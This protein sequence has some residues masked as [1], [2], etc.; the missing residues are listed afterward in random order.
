MKHFCV[1]GDPVEHSLSPR[2]HR[3]MIELT[4]LDATYDLCPVRAQE[5]ERFVEQARGGAWDGFNVTMP[6]K[7]AVVPYLDGLSGTA[8]RCRA[9]NTVCMEDGR[10]IGHNTDGLGFIESLRAHG[11]D[12]ADKTALIIGTGGAGE[13][14]TDALVQAGAR[15]VYICN[16]SVYRAQ[17]LAARYPEHT[18]WVYF[19]TYPVRRG[20]AQADLV[21]NATSL[22]MAGCKEFSD[23][24]FLGGVNPEAIVYD[25]VY[26]PRRTLFLSEADRHGLQTI[27][28]IELL[29]HQA[30]LAFQRWTGAE[31]GPAD[32][33][34]EL[35]KTLQNN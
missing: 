8:A 33:K 21:V 27:G 25:L 23:L 16:R 11:F 6:H 34:H 19:G 12:P 18:R 10:A 17:A 3:R 26:N 2:L 9:V 5:L 29:V 30:M 15:L 28:G 22:G 20:S 31:F 35:L 24:R 32:M 1:I 13:A 14:V 4:G 7:E